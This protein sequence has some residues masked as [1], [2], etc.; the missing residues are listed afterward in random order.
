[1]GLLSERG[2]ALVVIVGSLLGSLGWV[3]RRREKGAVQLT[4]MLLVPMGLLMALLSTPLYLG[5][6]TL[7]LERRPGVLVVT[8]AHL[9]DDRGVIKPGEP[10]PEGAFLE[11]GAR[12]GRLIEVRYGST[13]G[14]LPSGTVR[15]LRLR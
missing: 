15:V 4:G 9:T 2:W 11:L 3:L 5:A 1:M 6:R 7:R 8:E 12:Q 14:W 13:E 10:L